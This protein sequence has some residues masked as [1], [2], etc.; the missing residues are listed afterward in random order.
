MN[1]QVPVYIAE[2]APK[3]YWGGLA[4]MNQVNQS[5]ALERKTCTALIKL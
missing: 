5:E 4:A 2:I 3:D 1:K